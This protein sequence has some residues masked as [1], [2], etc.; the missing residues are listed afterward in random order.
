M[1]G[2]PG[3]HED[4]AMTERYIKVVL[5]AGSGDK[6]YQRTTFEQLFETKEQQVTEQA[7]LFPSVAAT[8]L[9]VM[10]RQK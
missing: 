7:D 9:E 1:P 8:V 5:E 4:R 10:Q 6:V 3:A 2:C